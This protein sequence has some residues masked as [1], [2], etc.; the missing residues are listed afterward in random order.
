MD[1]KHNSE[2]AKPWKCD[3]CP[4]TFAKSHLLHSHKLQHATEKPYLCP[5]S[6]CDKAFVHNSILKNHIRSVHEGIFSYFIKV[7]HKKYT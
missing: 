2:I 7:V 1:L 5:N 6:G 4:K 3:K